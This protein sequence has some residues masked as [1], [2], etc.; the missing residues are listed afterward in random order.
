MTTS[1]HAALDLLQQSPERLERGLVALDRQ[2]PL[3][4][5]FQ[6]DLLLRDA[7]GYPVVVLFTD[8]QVTVDLGRLA[9]AVGALH[10]SRHLLGRMFSHAGLDATLRPRFIL[11]APRFPDDA[12]AQLELLASVEVV[13]M[14]YRVVNDA[15]SRPV[16][17]LSLFHRT[18]GPAMV[19]RPLGAGE[20]GRS[21][22]ALSAV[23]AGRSTRLEP[24][25]PIAVPV[26]RPRAL[27]PATTAPPPAVAAPAAPQPPVAP[28]APAPLPTPARPGK[29]APRQVA[30][31][32]APP[33]PVVP[34]ASAPAT[35]PVPA[36]A[37]PVAP[38]SP[39]APAPAPAARAADPVAPDVARRLYL[40]ARELI[41]SLASQITENTEDG[42]VRFRAEDQLLAT[43][44]LDQDGFRMQIGDATGDGPVVTSDSMLDE[45]LNELFV[46]YF[47]R[48]G[49][50]IILE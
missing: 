17:E 23:A 37:A 15:D 19:T 33:T 12:A 4:E 48:M 49:P 3:D 6:I 46:L 38:A 29:S 1:K 47:S 45:K 42:R 32:A 21:V 40:R 26:A 22:G 25:E 31:P 30:P 24:S 41:R 28:A 8:G 34:V 27:P 50:E 36:A 20:L 44:R 39:A 5:Q 16:L 10:R 18:A 13:A 7:L 2:L 14:E 9:G 35:P 43:L 11:L